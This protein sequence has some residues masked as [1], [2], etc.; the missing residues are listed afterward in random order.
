MP[1]SAIRCI[2]RRRRCR[3]R[4]AVSADVRDFRK[5]AENR[6]LARPRNCLARPLTKRYFEKTGLDYGPGGNGRSCWVA[7]RR[8]GELPTHPKPAFFAGRRSRWSGGYHRSTHAPDCLQLITEQMLVCSVFLQQ[9][10]FRV[11]FFAG[12]LEPLKPLNQRS[13][14]RCSDLQHSV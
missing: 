10:T 12:S 5:W 2:S 7:Q 14:I 6:S 1:L 3:V 11:F 9:E 8:K 4:G 13:R